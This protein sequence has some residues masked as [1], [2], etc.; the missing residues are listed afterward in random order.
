[1]VFVPGLGLNER[2]WHK[3]RSLLNGPSVVE[4]LPSMGEPAPRGTDLFVDAQA[5]RLVKTFTIGTPLILVGHSA[6]C[7]VVVQAAAV[8]PDVVGLVLVGPVTD[9]AARTWPRMLAQ[10]LRSAA[11]EHPAE[12]AVLLPQYWRTGP[13]GM[14]R[15]MN[16][17]RWFRTD[18]TLAQQ[19]LPVEVVRG[20]NDRIATRDWSAHLRQVSQGTLTSVGA[21]GH[22]IPLTHPAAIVAAIERVRSSQRTSPSG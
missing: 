5:R 4:E 7:P 1:M 6:S 8:S 9:P 22:M 14:L 2:S 18:L 12:A 15:G 3:V 13:A 17:I 19:T 16:A 11:H 20:V 21:G 10:W